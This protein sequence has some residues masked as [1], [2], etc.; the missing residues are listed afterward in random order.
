MK[1]VDLHCHSSYSEHPTEWFLQKLGAKESYTDP[2]YIYNEARRNKMDYVTI[3]DHN[4]IDGALLLKEKYPESV[5]VGVEATTYFPEDKCKIHLLIYGINDLQFEI[6][7]H[8]R[9]DIYELREYIKQ[10]DL[11][12]SVAHASYSVNGKLDQHH[13][14]KLILLFDVF[15]AINGGRNKSSNLGWKS[16]L[17]N[18]DE[19]RLEDL[20]KTYRID[21]YSH[22]SWKKGFTAGSDDHGGLFLGKTYTAARANSIEEYLSALKQKRTTVFGRHNSYHA[23]AFT[24]YKIAYDF[25]KQ[26]QQSKKGGLISSITANLFENKGLDLKHRIKLKTMKSMAER[27]GD[28]LKLSLGELV[29]TL[30][31]NREQN[32]DNKL[33]LVYDQISNISDAFFRIFLNTFE[34]DLKDL[35]LVK[36]IRNISSS[37]PGIFLLLPFF[38]SLKHMHQNIKLVNDLRESYQI[39][40]ENR[41]RRTLWFTDTINDLNG[42][43]VTLKQMGHIASE[44]GRELKIVSSLESHEITNEIPPNFMNL[45]YMYIFRL[46]Y[47]ENLRIKIPSI[48]KALKLI[49]DFEPDQIIISTPGPIGL[50]ALL[51]AKLL[52]I[53]T[54]GIYHTDFTS[55]SSHI[56]TDESASSIVL[57]FE[58]WFYS[59]LDE[60]RTPTREYMNILLDRDISAPRMGLLNRGIETDKFKPIKNRKSFLNT[61]FNYQDGIDL[62]YAGRISKDKSLDLL[63]DVYKKLCVKHKELNLIISGNGPYLEEMKENLAG[64]ERVIF[65]GAV[66]RDLLPRLY[67]AADF[68]IFPSVTD[69]FGMVILE[70]QACGLPVI[71]SSQGGP[72]ELI[73]PDNT[74][75]VVE[76][77]SV[78][79]W[80]NTIE[81]ALE[82]Y[83]QDQEKYLRMREAC[84]QKIGE[85]TDWDMILDDLIGVDF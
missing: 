46:P 40:E 16:I 13:L 21:P 69:T 34:D 55:E 7:N 37:L 75:F 31:E 53:R 23:L 26:A 35:N 10:E 66:P 77:Q 48:L 60:I 85:E 59:Q 52:H 70:A 29:R 76:T 18:L 65:T 33:D 27:Q 12:H 15:E 6:I 84:R 9:K 24:V 1:K 79:A 5:I 17:D 50:L 14:E 64:F 36:L 51:A 43:S 4:K 30:K 11:A 20:Y 73:I 19:N 78:Q 38:S 41:K 39:R 57:G 49:N 56:I 42:V 67:N 45:P 8:I 80:Q 47:Y 68:F 82:T 71:V 72:K 22:N 28:E 83:I 58:K 3:T 2:F 81:S 44:R 54:I 25:S 61:K 74:G 62:F 32:I 63:A